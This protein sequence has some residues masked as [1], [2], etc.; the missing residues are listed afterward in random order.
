MNETVTSISALLWN[1]R[2]PRLFMTFHRHVS[3]TDN[4]N[5]EVF[6]GHNFRLIRS[7]IVRWIYQ[8]RS[9]SCD[10]RKKCAQLIDFFSVENLN[11]LKVLWCEKWPILLII[12]QRKK[13]IYYNLFIYYYLLQ[14]IFFNPTNINKWWGKMVFF[15]FYPKFSEFF[16]HFCL[17]L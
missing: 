17:L 12:L 6:C 14:L 2:F 13:T 11:I 1:S 7:S 15:Y 5:N 8:I 3:V 16:D 10:I 4:Y 9:H